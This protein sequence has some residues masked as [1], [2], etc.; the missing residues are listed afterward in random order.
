M[1]P[2]ADTGISTTFGQLP[3]PPGGALDPHGA[4]GDEVAVFDTKPE[5]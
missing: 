2:N 5:K 3:A 4:L 1:P